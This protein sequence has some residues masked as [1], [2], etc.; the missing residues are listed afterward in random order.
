LGHLHGR[1]G[2]PG[3]VVAQSHIRAR[4]RIGEWTLQRSGANRLRARI[5]GR[6]SLSIYVPSPTNLP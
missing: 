6:N 5:V 3:V 4:D 1:R 2:V